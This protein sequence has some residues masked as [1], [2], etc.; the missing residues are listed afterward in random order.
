MIASVPKVYVHS[1]LGHN[2]HQTHNS[3]GLDFSENHE[4]QDCSFEKFDAPVVY[5]VHNFNVSF[6]VFVKYNATNIQFNNAVVLN[7][8][9]NNSYLRGPPVA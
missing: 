7:S 4:T 2:H 1:L 9:F 5:T 3:K 8:H 6:S